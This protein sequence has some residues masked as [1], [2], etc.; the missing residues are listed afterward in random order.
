MV[1]V[2]SKLKHETII[3]HPRH[4]S[5]VV[6][7][8]MYNTTISSSNSNVQLEVSVY[9][10]TTDSSSS[11]SP[12]ILVFVHPWGLLGGSWYNT[13]GLAKRCSSQGYTS[14]IFNLR[15][16]GKST[17]R[18][19][20]CG[21][22]EVH[23]VVAVAEFVFNRYCTE[24]TSKIWL[25]AQSAGAPTAG[26]AARKLG[27][28]KCSGAVFI[29][30]T[31]GCATSVLFGRHYA[32]ASRFSPTQRALHII[33]TADCFTTPA[34]MKRA[35]ARNQYSTTVF[36]LDGVGH[37]EIEAPQY[38]SL[39]ASAV[40]CFVEIENE[41]ENN[42]K[43]FEQVLRDHRS[44]GSVFQHVPKQTKQ[45]SCFCCPPWSY[46]DTCTCFVF[47]CLAILVG[48]ITLVILVSEDL[49]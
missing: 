31:F 41:N 12:H 8:E 37:F 9:L 47:W 27:I 3:Y 29:G 46:C 24:T 7:P 15:G 36:L 16:V 19:T 23:D 1:T 28:D 45:P 44:N 49:L 26:S 6:P 17:G 33:G 32:A 40:V 39:V 20:C 22:S 14:V 5:A 48:I 34:S 4:T 2:K 35:V 10:P 18:A 21:H 42:V 30:Y 43:Q 13:K 38:D 11:S 25:V